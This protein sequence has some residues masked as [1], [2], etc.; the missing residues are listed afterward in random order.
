MQKNGY[1]CGVFVI[2]YVQMILQLFSNSTN[3]E[4]DSKFKKQFQQSFT[5]SDV[6]KERIIYKEELNKLREELYF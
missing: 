2:K 1:D 5:Q 4:I 6:T 3:E